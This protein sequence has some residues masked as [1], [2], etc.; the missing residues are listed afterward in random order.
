MT[1][2]AEASINSLDARRS[3]DGGTLT[4]I[5]TGRWDSDTTGKWWQRGQQMLSQ[6]KPRRLVI[7]A[8]GVSYCDGAGVAFLIDL[9]Q[10]QIRTGGDATIQGLQEE[11]RR[12]LDIYGDISI[13]R[14]P[15]RRRE[16]LSIIEQ[17]GKAAVELWRDLQ[18]LLTFVGE[19]ALTL[20]RA[21]R[22]PRL[23]RWKD[24]WLVAE[25]SGVDA[26]PIIALIGVLLGLI[27]A[28]QSA[29]PMR[30]FGADIFVADL[31][32]IAMLREMGPLI[33]AI[34]LAGRS[35]SAFAAELGTMKVREEIDALRT[36][37][38]EPVRF[39]V[40]PRVIAAVA[41]IPV[42]TVFA[43]LFG[44]MGG[45][46]VM[47]SLGYPL[48]TYVNQVLSAVTVGDLM[49]GLLKSF[50]YGI[51]V[52]AVGCLRGLETKTGASAVG[53]S[54]T[55]AVVSGIV[56]IAIVDGL[57]AVVFHALGL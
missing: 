43:N 5:M 9:Q 39:L 30:R 10:L 38:L 24:A 6:G 23:V 32:G 29:I 7:D 53:Q 21:A 15:G 25:Q 49:G 33:T 3:S 31:L 44:L 20:L 42:L 56:L 12:L 37:G 4:L 55:S 11:F 50:V 27:L 46:I 40:L 52:A 28:F 22:H 36:M 2:A 35:G 8:S 47:R 1:P 16:P 54:T 45:A 34:I 13:N 17:V 26:L 48:V 14:P 41:M 57:F 18:A 19:L 51:V